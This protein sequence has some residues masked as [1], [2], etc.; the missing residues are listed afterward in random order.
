MEKF[1]IADFLLRYHD[2]MCNWTNAAAAVE[3]FV[4]GVEDSLLTA[5][6]TYKDRVNVYPFFDDTFFNGS[7]MLKKIPKAH[8]KL[9][10]KQFH[11]PF[12]KNIENRNDVWTIKHID[13]PKSDLVH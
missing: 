6:P 11:L 8:K 5:D 3:W 1:Q 9:K 13:P 12:K 4:E 2:D 10:L 7:L